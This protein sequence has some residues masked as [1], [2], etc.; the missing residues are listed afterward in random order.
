MKEHTVNKNSWH[1]KL[2]NMWD[3]WP[4]NNLCDYTRQVIC[5]FFMV[6]AMSFGLISMSFLVIYGTIIPYIAYFFDGISLQFGSWLIAGFILGHGAIIVAIIGI[7][8][9]KVRA[10]MKTMPQGTVSLM[11]E[12]FKEKTC[13]KIK[14]VD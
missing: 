11:Y 7:S 6:L 3:Y 14:F 12:N 5:G 13:S 2:A 1:Y 9:N 8:Y 10:K 4:S